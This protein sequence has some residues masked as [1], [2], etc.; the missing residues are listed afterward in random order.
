MAKFD[1]ILVWIYVSYT[2]SDIVVYRNIKSF[3]LES[4]LRNIDFFFNRCL[5]YH[6]Y[7][8]IIGDSTLKNK[9]I[10]SISKNISYKIYYMQHLTFDELL[11]VIIIDWI[12][13]LIILLSF[14]LD[15]FIACHHLIYNSIFIQLCTTGP[16]KWSAN[17]HHIIFEQ[18]INNIPNICF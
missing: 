11:V 10:P 3:T 6:F 17:K 12:P 9:F 2:S 13:I 18:H 1:S 15:L 7:A 16:I 5:L 8:N 14:I 4:G